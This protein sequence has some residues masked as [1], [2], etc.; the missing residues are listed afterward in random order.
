VFSPQALL[1]AG[2]ALI[3]YF[4]IGA[5]LVVF[6]V[7]HETL[8]ARRL[9]NA[10]PSLVRLEA[11]LQLN[12]AAATASA[13]RR[14]AL[15]PNARGLLG[16]AYDVLLRPIE[17]LL[18][19]YERLIVVPHGRLQQLPFSALHDGQRY[20]LERFE[21]ATAP[22]ASALT[23]C[24]RP[25]ERDT[26]RLFVGA[27]SADGALPA[28]ID[29]AHSIAALYGV[30]P[31]V[32]DELTLST[33]RTQAPRA[34]L[35]HLAAHGVGR[36][37]APLFSYIRMADGHQTALD[38]FDQQLDCALVTLSAC[39]SGRGIVAAGDEQIGLPRAFL[40]AGARAVLHS[41]WRID[42]RSTRVL[43]ERFYAEL[44]AGRAKAA[45]LRTAQLAHIR[46]GYT[47]PLLWASLTLVGDWR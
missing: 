15:E 39:E 38:C 11:P 12:L 34:D 42:D 14:V 26:Q 5:D 24:L 32:E 31:V 23:F 45:A 46:D 1:G 10:S 30:R 35:I 27:H 22:S 47:H 21:V 9:E 2:T 41:L 6:I 33:L 43:M 18:A 3:E 25:R 19:P 4:R 44:R 16:R 29:E 17:E 7:D 28:A 13:D 37:D 8:R 20:L 36:I 40:Y